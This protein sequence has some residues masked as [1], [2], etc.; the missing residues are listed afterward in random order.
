MRP[1]L[2]IHFEQ[3]EAKG[4]ERMKKSMSDDI[5]KAINEAEAEAERRVAEAQRL[6]D[7]AVEKTTAK[8]AERIKKAED[9]ADKA[10]RAAEK[11]G[12]ERASEIRRKHE[13]AASAEAE[14]MLS[15]ALTKKNEAIS[16]VVQELIGK[17]Q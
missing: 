12:E 15:S 11:K 3:N 14:T 16:E 10:I 9:D 1:R 7:E 4:P 6:A 17:W 5:M 13:E 8:C 2:N